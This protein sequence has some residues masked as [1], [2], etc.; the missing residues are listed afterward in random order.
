MQREKSGV[1]LA[2]F[3]LGGLL[4]GLL[5]G[6]QGL[7][8]G[9]ASHVQH[10]L[11]Y[12][13]PGVVLDLQREWRLGLDNQRLDALVHFL[14]LNSMRTLRSAETLTPTNHD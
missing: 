2:V 7:Q 13:A 5:Q 9:A 11:V 10:G 1:L 6:L 14:V 8:G 3:V 12:Q 4:V